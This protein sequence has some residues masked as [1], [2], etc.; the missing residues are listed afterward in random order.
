MTTHRK[1]TDAELIASCDYYVSRKLRLRFRHFIKEA[2]AP[3]RKH[4]VRQVSHSRRV[5]Y[6]RDGQLF[7]FFQDHEQKLTASHAT[8]DNGKTVVYDIRLDSPHLN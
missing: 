6:V 5:A 8:L 3:G 1:A 2:Y 7:V 4:D